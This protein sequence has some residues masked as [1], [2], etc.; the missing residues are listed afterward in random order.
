MTTIMAASQENWVVYTPNRTTPAR[1]P[2]T[3]EI[4]EVRASLIATGDASVAS[5]SYTV[6]G[7]VVRFNRV[8]GG[9]KGL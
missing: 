2:K 1:F 6:E 4:E 9:S 7:D 8:Q 5:A 3:M